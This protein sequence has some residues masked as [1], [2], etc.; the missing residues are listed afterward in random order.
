MEEEVARKLEGSVMS[1]VTAAVYLL[2]LALSRDFGTSTPRT[3]DE[4]LKEHGLPLHAA[5]EVWV[6]AP[7]WT[8]WAG[9]WPTRA[10]RLVTAGYHPIETKEQARKLSGEVLISCSEPA[11]LRGRGDLLLWA[12]W[13]GVE[14]ARATPFLGNER[15]KGNVLRDGPTP[16]AFSLPLKNPMKVTLVFVDKTGHVR[17]TERHDIIELA[18]ASRRK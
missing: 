8:L 6:E 7:R 13:I 11:E 12:H 15:P 14:M 2:C 16:K 17:Q 4:V 5:K 3:V 10:G 18:H 9:F 1:P